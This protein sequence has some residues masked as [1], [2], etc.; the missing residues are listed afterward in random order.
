MRIFVDKDL[1]CETVTL[2][3]LQ[4]RAVACFCKDIAKDFICK[5]V[6]FAFRY[7]KIEPWVWNFP[8]AF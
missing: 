1:C 6:Y 2:I 5:I 4:D 7:K 3:C 8:Q